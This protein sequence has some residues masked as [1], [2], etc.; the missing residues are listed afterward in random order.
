MSTGHCLWKTAQN[1]DV[2]IFDHQYL[3]LYFY[4]E[5]YLAFAPFVIIKLKSPVNKPDKF[6][7]PVHPLLIKLVA[8]PGGYILFA[9]SLHRVLTLSDLKDLSVS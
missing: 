4:S 7:C 2:I 3:F 9:P 6:R 8:C 5:N 1:L